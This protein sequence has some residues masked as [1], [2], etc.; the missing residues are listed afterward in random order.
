MSYLHGK[1]Q[2][3][4][5]NDHNS[6]MAYEDAGM[7]KQTFCPTKLSTMYPVLEYNLPKQKTRANVC[8]GFS[9]IQA[10]MDTQFLSPEE[11]GL[12]K[13][14]WIWIWMIIWAIHLSMR[15]KMTRWN[16]HLSHSGCLCEPY[17]ALYSLRLCEG[18]QSTGSI[19]YFLHR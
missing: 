7:S 3:C 2:S 19:G 12:V 6:S 8:W 4:Q 17:N 18:L 9:V 1:C 15:S 11:N 16:Q 10:S 14:T 13:D 5:W